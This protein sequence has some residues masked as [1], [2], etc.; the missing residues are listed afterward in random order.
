MR[1]SSSPKAATGEP[2]LRARTSKPGGASVIASPWLI[3][4]ALVAGQSVNSGE[5]ETRETSVRPYSPMGVRATVPPSCWA[6]SCAP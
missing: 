2:S 5:D 6:V 1:R 3:H 4:T